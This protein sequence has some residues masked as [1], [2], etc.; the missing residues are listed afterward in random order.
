M[1]SALSSVAYVELTPDAIT[2]INFL[3]LYEE[4]ITF[5]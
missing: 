4:L 1:M 5:V 2:N 3:H